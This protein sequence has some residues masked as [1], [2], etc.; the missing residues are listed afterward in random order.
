M[1]C[2]E[3]LIFWAQL[4]G[5]W[6]NASRVS[7]SGNL[8]INNFKLLNFEVQY[9]TLNLQLFVK[10]NTALLPSDS[11]KVVVCLLTVW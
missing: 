1:C 8:K 3:D 6:D 11:S 4:W 5:F 9:V 2:H 10:G 7:Y